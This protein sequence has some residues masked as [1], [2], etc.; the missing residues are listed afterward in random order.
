MA[1]IKVY[2]ARAGSAKQIAAAVGEGAAAL[3]HVRQYL[4]KHRAPGTPR[5]GCLASATVAAA[6]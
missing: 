2:D 5:R 6:R 1:D 3:L 4:Q